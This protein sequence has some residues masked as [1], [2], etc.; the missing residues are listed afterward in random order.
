LFLDGSLIGLLID[1][2]DGSSYVLP[3]YMWISIRLHG[4]ICQYQS[5]FCSQVCLYTLRVTCMKGRTSG[6]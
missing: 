3:K 4:V 5:F 2:E 6:Q 1:P